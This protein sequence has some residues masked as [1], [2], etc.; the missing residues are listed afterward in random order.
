MKLNLVTVS[1]YLFLAS[2]ALGLSL[3]IRY[4]LCLTIIASHFFTFKYLPSTNKS[5]LLIIPMI[6]GIIT[7]Y[8]NGYYPVGKDI[9][10]LSFPVVFLHVGYCISSVLDINKLVRIILVF[11]V[12]IMFKKTFLAISSIGLAAIAN[13]I[14]ARYDVGFL[15][16]PAPVLALGTMLS[17]TIYYKKY[18]TKLELST[19]VLLNAFGVYMMA[20]RS[21]ILFGL[22]FLFWYFAILLKKQPRAL[23]LYI[24]TIFVISMSAYSLQASSDTFIGKLLNSVNELSVNDYSTE[25]DINVKYRGY[26]TFMAGETYLEG[27][28][29]E[30]IFGSLGK[31][32]DLKTYVTLMDEAMRFIPILHNGY[33]YL[34]IKAGALGIMVYAYF[35]LSEI[36]VN[37]KQLWRK[38]IDVKVAG[39]L[40][41]GIILSLLIS[42]YL[43][44]GLFN[45]EMS[46]F[47]ILYGYLTYYKNDRNEILDNHSYL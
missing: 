2:V 16:D 15:G 3:P 9:Y 22:S 12:I 33:L 23:I 32:I 19:F 40:S 39:Y 28:F 21:Y 20:S 27:S 31:P 43:I 17:I 47:L 26:E 42:T 30:M 46:L 35:F 37:I 25:E 10:Y 34:L 18:F 38:N 1:F 29:N 4:I 44:R 36:I 41:L 24:G 7:G 13:P 5:R 8:S 14:L 11:G 45:I 6:I